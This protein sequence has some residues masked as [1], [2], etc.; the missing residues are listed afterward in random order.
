MRMRWR[1][2]HLFSL[3]RN[4]QMYRQSYGYIRV[5]GMSHRRFWCWIYCQ[6]RSDRPSR[7]LVMRTVCQNGLERGSVP[8]VEKR[9]RKKYATTYLST[10]S[11]EQTNRTQFTRSPTPQ[12]HMS[13]ASQYWQLSVQYISLQ[14]KDEL[15]CNRFVCPHTQMN[16]PCSTD[17]RMNEWGICHNWTGTKWLKPP[18]IVQFLRKYL[19]SVCVCV[20]AL[21]A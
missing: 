20:C 15:P 18:K 14:K 17:A 8:S 9:S 16:R 2:R 6:G 3:H 11:K 7:W 5:R 12:N 1:M 10:F 21:H 4:G 13:S 19:C